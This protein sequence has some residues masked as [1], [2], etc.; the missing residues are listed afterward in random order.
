MADRVI[1]R[2][3]Y[4]IVG[5]DRDFKKALQKST[6][7]LDKTAQ[8]FQQIGKGL[9]LAVTAPLVGLGAA[10]TKAAIE[11]EETQNKFNVAFRGIEDDAQAAADNLSDNFGLANDEAQRLLAGTGDLLKGFGATAEEAL[12]LSSQVQTLAVDLAS[13]NNLAGGT[14][15][16][17]QAITAALLGERE[18]LKQLGVV[19]RQ[20]DVDQRLLAKGQ[21]DLTGQAR[22]QAQAQATLELTMEQSA[23]AIG[24]YERS[25]GSAAQQIR[26][27]KA[28]TRDMAVELGQE[29]L[30]V[31]Q[32]IL[33]QV[34][35]LV[36]G[37]SELSDAQKTNIVRIAAVAAA[38]GP[39]T[40]GIGTAIKA[41]TALRLAFVALSA[42]PI[43]LAI[44]GLTAGVVALGLALKRASTDQHAEDME[45]Y[46]DAA[47]EAGVSVNQ[48]AND[49]RLAQTALKQQLQYGTDLETAINNIASDYSLT[50]SQVVALARELDGYVDGQEDVLDAIEEQSRA[51]DAQKEDMEQL[52]SLQK[53][54]AEFAAAERQDQ[55]EMAAAAERRAAAEEAALEAQREARSEAWQETLTEYYQTQEGQ[56]E[57]LT[58]ELEQYQEALNNP[59]S[60]LGVR[61]ERGR[62][63]VRAIIADLEKEIARRRESLGLV[64]E[65]NDA[66]EQNKE[67]SANLLWIEQ[68]RT[69]T[70]EDITESLTDF[71]RVQNRVRRDAADWAREYQDLASSA[72]DTWAG[73]MQGLG[74]AIVDT[75]DG[76]KSVGQAMVQMFTGILNTLGAQFAAMAAA[77]AFGMPPTFIPN[78][79]QAAGYG[80]ASAGFYG[81]SGLVSA[82]TAFGDGGSF[83]ADQPQAIVVGDK[84]EYVDIRPV[85]HAAP[86]GW[87]P[88]GGGITI[89]GDVYGY[90]DFARKVE[91]AT[92][93]SGRLGRTGRR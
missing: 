29:L 91:Q 48:I 37:F 7:E 13:Y 85:D 2:L 50:R 30:P 21:Q 77:A 70:T 16:A 18:Q 4:K 15:Q 11:A 52:R 45:R 54:R 24:D 76:L 46:A 25:G 47:E 65:Q 38:I 9:S 80:V 67:H 87:G 72:G 34:I 43:V 86:P 19:I 31:V 8:R 39:L 32:A 10:M 49:H 63:V 73:V 42:N 44:A 53:D 14:E 6:R 84:P 88:G 26:E 55:E 1:G 3:A 89:V 27:L 83:F 20:T 71:E 58:R 17:S 57:I 69:G 75:E 41:V 36:Q 51:Q 5:D 66:L 78:P 28:Q 81:A 33:A 60:D 56:L 40:A 82:I 23:D 93:R 12:G 74:Q 35:D 79:A 64:G 62:Q 68:R 90:N 22:L 59:E 92:A 61:T